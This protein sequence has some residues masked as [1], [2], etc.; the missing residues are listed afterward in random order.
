MIS[1]ATRVTRRGPLR[2]DSWSLERYADNPETDLWFWIGSALTQRGA[3]AQIRR[4]ER[5]VAIHRR[6][7]G[8][9]PTHTEGPA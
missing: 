7:F 4:F 3:R 6:D 8:G 9:A 5:L 1:V 2:W